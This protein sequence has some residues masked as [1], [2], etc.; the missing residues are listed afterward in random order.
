MRKAAC[1]KKP[2]RDFSRKMTSGVKIADEYQA[3][4]SD[5]GHDLAHAKSDKVSALALSAHFG[6]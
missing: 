5:D 1:R 6:G 2:Q 3:E 4:E